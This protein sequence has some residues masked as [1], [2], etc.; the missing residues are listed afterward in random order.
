MGSSQ[1][2]PCLLYFQGGLVCHQWSHHAARFLAACSKL[3]AQLY[4]HTEHECCGVMCS[5]RSW[6]CLSVGVQI[7]QTIISPG[8]ET[9]NARAHNGPGGCCWP[10]LWFPGECREI[11]ELPAL[12]DVW[13]AFLPLQFSALCANGQLPMQMVVP[14]HSEIKLID[15]WAHCSEQRGPAERWV[16]CG[17]DRMTFRNFVVIQYKWQQHPGRPPPWFG[18]ALRH[19]GHLKEL[20]PWCFSWLWCQWREV[21]CCVLFWHTDV[22]LAPQHPKYSSEAR[23]NVLGYCYIYTKSP[24]AL[25]WD[26]RKNFMDITC[27]FTYSLMYL[28]GY[29]YIMILW[30]CSDVHCIHFAASFMEFG[31]ELSAQWCLFQ[32]WFMFQGHVNYCT[33][34]GDMGK[35]CFVM[36]TTCF[37]NI[38]VSSNQK[39]TFLPAK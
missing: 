4:W 18:N 8:A 5:S 16:P 7:L 15:W 35:T 24:C 37:A 20:G 9:L 29:L 11:Q 14:W 23:H 19:T 30:Q 33:R 21:I 28:C 3:Q 2:R 34:S 25:L 32:E 39:W 6:F 17:W 38:S 27:D 22:H 13:Q 26:L 10:P 31:G 36:W 1:S 12:W